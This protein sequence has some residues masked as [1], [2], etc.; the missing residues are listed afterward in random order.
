[1]VNF[2]NELLVLSGEGQASLNLRVELVL[3]TL[4]LELLNLGPDLFRDLPGG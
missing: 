2:I 3:A 4:L 1:L